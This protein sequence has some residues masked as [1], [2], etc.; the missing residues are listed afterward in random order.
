MTGFSRVGTGTVRGVEAL[1]V[2]VECYRG[3]GL[4]QAALVGLARG[5]VRE[6]LVRVRSAIAASGIILESSRLVSN[7]LPAEIPKDAS[8]IDLALAVAILGAY[9]ELPADAVIGR[10][11][12]GELSLSGRLEPCRGAV[13]VADLVRQKGEKE[14]FVPRANAQ[15]A[16]LVPG[17]DVYAVEHLSELVAHLRGVSPLRKTVRPSG[18]RRP[19]RESVDLADVAGQERAKRALEIAA[20]G[21]HN[22]LLIGP[23]GSG[24]TMLAHRLPTLM[25]ELNTDESAELTRIYSASGMLKGETWIRSRPFRSPH[26]TSS[27]TALCGGGSPLR[28]G[29]VTLAHLGVLFLDELPEF[30]RRAIETLREPLESGVVHV[31]RASERAVFPARTLMVAAMNPCPCGFYR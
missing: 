5:A 10:R 21:H 8:S 1:P 25:P 3:K 14:L 4:P 27:W 16:A 29:E 17:I 11:F 30:S 9:G 12:F 18:A 26:H 15:E 19:S 28:P 7:L 6:A 23:P 2:T 13:L 22:L 31:A 20:A 24:K